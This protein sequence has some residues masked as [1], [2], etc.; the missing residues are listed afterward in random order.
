MRYLAFGLAFVLLYTVVGLLLGDHSFARSLFGN[1]ALVGTA[2]LVP[3]VVFKRRSSWSGCQRLFF[4]ILA[5]AVVLWIVGHT[6]WAYDQLRYQE[7]T[8]LKWHTIFSLC[9]GF[10]P[11]VALLARPHLGPRNHVVAPVAMTIAAY[12]LLAV[13]VYSYF[14]LV[15]SVMPAGRPAA[16]EK[17]LL[18]VE[19]NR[20]L[21]LAALVWIYWF[22]RA[23]DWGR[24]YLTL[25]A[26]VAIGLLLRIGTNHAIMRG[27]YEVGSLYDLA[28]IGPWLFYAS[29]AAAAPPSP[30]TKEETDEPHEVMSVSLLAAPAL[31]IPLIGY[32][33]LNFEAVGEPVESF[34]LFLT[35]LTTV[36]ALGL[37]T[38]RLAAQGGELQRTDARLQLLAAATE[39]TGDLILIA[40]PDG[41]F[42]HANAAFLRAFGYSRPEL[43]RLKFTDLIESGSDRLGRSITTEVQSTGIW[44]GTLLGLRKDKSTFPAACT[45]TALR[46]GSGRLTHFVGV[47]RDM[48]EDIKLRDQLVHSERLSAIGELIAGVAHEINNPLQTIIGC[49]ELMLD[50]P[51]ASNRADLE[52]VRK[53][54]MRAGQIVRNLLAFARRGAPD[55]M[56]VDLNAVVRATADLRL[57]HLQQ[58]NIA[59]NLRCTPAPLPV[60][61]NREEI[62]QVILNLLL[63]AEHAIATSGSNGGSITMETGFVDGMHTL[64]VTDSGPGVSPELRGRIFEPFFTTREVGQGTGL[65]L[66]I[67]LGIVSSHGGSLTLVDSPVGARFRLSLPAPADTGALARAQST[68][69]QRALVVVDDESM[70]TWLAKLLER[71][72]FA[73]VEASTGDAAI[74]AAMDQRPE[75]VI[76]DAAVPGLS[77]VEMYRQ[78]AARDAEGSPRFVFISAEKRDGGFPVTDAPVL[79]KPFT[80]SDLEAALAEAG[81]VPPGHSSRR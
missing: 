68:A 32:G 2:A 24:T 49:T 77:G 9:A 39:H 16:Q 10:G 36:V 45:I 14:I 50:E 30:A 29:A 1:L 27:D 6:G 3:I 81:V 13:F 53:E 64:E 60:L 66:S 43:I 76:C 18:F 79:V 44:R 26:G 69:P 74:A 78:L 4:D 70:R 23:T 62:R 56:I 54:A 41:T 33:V 80:A 38:L 51:G 65:G 59:L 31:L 67:S 11:L 57:Y 22:A 15:P 12:C 34:R 25:A 52:L 20:F 48:T 21:L 7:Q 8:W 71:R 40:R 17:L 5:I 46:D 28:W 72:G 58:V 55:R 61:A 63:N 35:S 42:E 75:V 37:V 19:A 47:E 73:V